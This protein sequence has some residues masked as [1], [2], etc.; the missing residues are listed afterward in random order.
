MNVRDWTHRYVLKFK[1]LKNLVDEKTSGKFADWFA[2]TAQK[3][4]KYASLRPLQ[5]SCIYEISCIYVY[6]YDERK[7]Y[8]ANQTSNMLQKDFHLL[9][10]D[11][12]TLQIIYSG[13][14]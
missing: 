11:V 3:L 1:I 8:I 5:F 9:R 7:Y 14:C 10:N 12:I 4:S 6:S 2:K 13:V